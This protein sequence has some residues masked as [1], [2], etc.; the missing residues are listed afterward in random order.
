MYAF[1]GD[2][3]YGYN[4]AANGGSFDRETGSRVIWK[5]PSEPGDYII[6]VSSGSISRTYTVKVVESPLPATD[7]SLEEPGPDN[8]GK[9]AH[10]KF[11]NDSGKTIKAFRI[12]IV[13]WDSSGE[14]I[15]NLYSDD[16]F[17]GRSSEI[18]IPPN[19]F[20]TDDFNVSWG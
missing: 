9:V 11:R 15:T 1:F 12:C 14:R 6:T 17:H 4:W 16:I 18:N 7:W 8:Y 19:A 13:L 3:D 5:A 10:I 20:F 2:E